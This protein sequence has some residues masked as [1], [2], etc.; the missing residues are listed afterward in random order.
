MSGLALADALQTAN[1]DF[2]LLEAGDR[3]G[4]RILSESYR[5]AAFDMGPAWFWPGQPR[6]AK[7]V[8]RFELESFEQYADGDF[9]YEDHNGLQRGQG[10]ASMEGSYRL[11]GGLGSLVSSLKDT[12]PSGSLLSK[13]PVQRLVC[14]NDQVVA[15]TNEKSFA[16]KRVVL[17]MPPRIAAGIDF[18]P[19]LHQD[20][21]SALQNTATW[22]AGQAK[23]VAI[24]DSPFWREIGLSGD[25][26][27]RTGP[28]VE[29][30]DASP[31]SEGLYALFGFIGVPPDARRDQDFLRKQLVAQLARLFGEKAARPLKLQI[32]D[33]AFDSY[34][35][36]L[37]DH[38]PLTSH[39]AY[40]LPAALKN[41][42]QGRLLFSGSEV[43]PQ[44]GGFLEGAL[45]AAENAIARIEAL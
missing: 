21:V 41:V 39:P 45:E 32:K 2:V 18:E 23:A 11:K 17:A 38:A 35:S 42:W 44:F 34:T 5:D 40:G 33:W 37:E 1:R 29:L 3:F 26:M 14:S 19:A 30:H 4:G 28:M 16:A 9:I 15:H 22:M 27:S 10:F 43:A 25:A 7:L 8:T 13:A 36:T 20:A 31:A 24:Y 6:M 12:L